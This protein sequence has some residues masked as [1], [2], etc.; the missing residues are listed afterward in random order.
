[1]LRRSHK[2]SRRGCLEC[3]RRHIKVCDSLIYHGV[4]YSGSRGQAILQLDSSRRLGSLLSS[5][6]ATIKPPTK[7]DRNS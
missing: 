1:M 6:S 4:L 7:E 2:K 3:K 5:K